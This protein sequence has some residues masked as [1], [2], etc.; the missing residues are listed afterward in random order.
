LGGGFF[1]ELRVFGKKGF[2][3]RIGK[4]DLFLKYVSF[5]AGM[6]EYETHAETGR[7]GAE[8]DKSKDRSCASPRHSCS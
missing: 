4:M 5:T 1:D 7:E 3:L 6:E 8:E 2:Y